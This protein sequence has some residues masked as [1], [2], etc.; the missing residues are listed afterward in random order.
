M[1]EFK[2][3][4]KPQ[5]IELDGFDMLPH[6]TNISFYFYYENIGNVN[7]D[8]FMPPEQLKT[9]FYKAMA[10]FPILAGTAKTDNTGKTYIEIT[11]DNLNKMVYTDSQCDTH[12][13]AFKDADFNPS[14][15]PNAFYEARMVPAPPGY[16]GG[17]IKLVE[18]HI[19]RMKDCSGIVIF[20]SVSHMIFD[21]YGFS[22][23]I[24]RWAEINKAMLSI[25]GGID[26]VIPCTCTFLQDRS[27]L[28]IGRSSE[29]DR[30]ET[31]I[32]DS[33][34]SSRTLSKWLSWIS[35]ELR[36]RMCK[37]ACY[38]TKVKNCYYHISTRALESLRSSI[39]EYVATDTPRLSINDV[40]TAVVT[41]V[42]SQCTIL[43]EQGQKGAVATTRY[44]LNKIIGGSTDYTLYYAV[45]T[46]LRLKHLSDVV[47][48][49]N[50][51]FLRK[52]VTPKDV[53]QNNSIFQTLAIVASHIRRVVV[54]TDAQYVG[55]FGY[56]VNKEPD[57]YMRF[58]LGHMSARNAILVSSQTRISYYDADFGYGIPTMVKPGFL[59]FPNVVLPMPCR[60]GTDGYDIAFTVSQAVAEKIKQHRFF[61]DLVSKF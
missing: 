30:V 47:Y 11:R 49:G 3:N 45:D 37:L 20:A 6:I 27:I 19:V 28:N 26:A 36:G 43:D 56:M 40:I 53:L 9:A 33:L 50:S 21:A 48:T 35:P 57:S 5:V 16:F 34:S 59:T 25:T 46:R 32:C 12:F 15:L 14:L 24:N 18:I 22:S 1:E 2:A 31:D 52:I 29:S 58:I 13:Q 39:Q 4:I 8:Q 55:Q 61:M 41:V 44:L 23:F 7:N 42:I 54:D 38:Y 17:C 60:P 51:V 10:E